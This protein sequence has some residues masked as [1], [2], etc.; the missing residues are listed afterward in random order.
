MGD[1]CVHVSHCTEAP[2]SAPVWA[3]SM[4]FEPSL[5][6]SLINQECLWDNCPQ[7]L[8]KACLTWGLCFCSR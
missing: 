5:I 6:M 8:G 1:R 4:Q 7:P 2:K 3:R